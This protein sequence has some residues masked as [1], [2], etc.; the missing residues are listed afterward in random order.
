MY[1][2]RFDK[3]ELNGQTVMNEYKCP[4]L[5]L[6]DTIAGLTPSSIVREISLMHECTPSCKCIENRPNIQV[7]RETIETNRLAYVHDLTNKLYCLNIYCMN[8]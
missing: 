3:F 5:T 8:Q 2:G 1:S 6:S 7:E 4:L